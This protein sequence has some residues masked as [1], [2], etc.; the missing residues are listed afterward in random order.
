MLFILRDPLLD[1]VA[2][3]LVIFI[4][5]LESH[6]SLLRIFSCFAMDNLLDLQDFPFL[7]NLALSLDQR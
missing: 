6:A 4:G 1:Y 5:S 2:L 7:R 3:N